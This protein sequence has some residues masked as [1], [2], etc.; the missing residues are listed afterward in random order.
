MI[1]TLNN[2]VRSLTGH[3]RPPERGRRIRIL[4]SCGRCKNTNTEH[5]DTVNRNDLELQSKG[6]SKI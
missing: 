6:Q 1:L 3:T 4:K 5:C 2:K